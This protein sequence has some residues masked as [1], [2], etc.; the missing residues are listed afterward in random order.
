MKVVDRVLM[1]WQERLLDG[2]E[3]IEASICRAKCD[4]WNGPLM[5][6]GLNFSQLIDKIREWAD[7]NIPSALWIDVQCEEWLEDEPDWSLDEDGIGNC[8][9]D[10]IQVE[11]PLLMRVLL[12]ELA[13]YV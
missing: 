2:H 13:S 3:D 8:P 1:E 4:L 11:R 7:E 12:G 5:D 10:F 9:D 6:S